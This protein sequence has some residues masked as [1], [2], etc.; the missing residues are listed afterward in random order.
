M[1][2]WH[3]F[4]GPNA[5]YVLELYDRYRESPEAVDPATRAIFDK[6]SPDGRGAPVAAEL[7]AAK[8]AG[9]INLAQAIRHYG[10]LAAALDP[11]RPNDRRDPLLELETHGLDED[12]LR[13]L[14]ASLVGGAAAATAA[15]A[16]EA[17]RALR[18]IYSSTMGYSYEH[19]HELRE[20]EWLRDAAE[21]RRFRPRAS[22]P[23]RIP[24]EYG[25]ETRP[26]PDSFDAVALLERLTR[27]EVLEHFLHRT[28]PGKTRFS[29]E[30]LDM[31]VPVLDALIWEAAG[32]GD[33]SRPRIRNVILGMAHRGRLNV[34]ANILNKPIRQILAEFQDPVRARDFTAREELGWTG[35]VKYHM[36]AQSWQRADSR[37]LEIAVLMPPNPSHLE[38]ID[39]VVEGMARAE[40]TDASAPGAPR[41]DPG[42]SLPVLVHGDASFPGQGIV[43]ETLN[44]SRL[45]GYRTGGTIHII[46]NNQLGYTTPHDEG[47]ST[48]YA[49]DL[50]K[51]F[52]IPIVHVN[53][54]DPEACIEAARLAAAYRAE[55]HKD[56][57]INLVGYRRYGHNEGD[58]PSFTQ[59]LMYAR[60][61]AHP[62]VRAQW[63]QTLVE[64]GLI[65]KELPERLVREYADELQRALEAVRPED[66]VDHAPPPPPQGAARRVKTAVPL[67]DLAALNDA[68]LTLPDGFALN[69]KLERAMARRRKALDDA[70]ARSIDW[71]TAEQLAFASILQAGTAIRFTGQDVERGTFSQR[72][73]V[74]HDVRTGATFTPLQS[75]PQA[76]AAF[77]IHNSPLSEEATIGFEY[78]YN[79]QK[80][81]RLVVWEAQ[82]GDF[83]NVA[84]SV[85]DEFLV[86]ARAKWGQTPSLVLLLPHAWE[87]QGPD[88][89]SGRLERFLALAA[90]TNLRIAFPTTAAQ[91]WH[92]L[93]RQALLLKTDPLPLIVMTPK[94]LLRDPRVAS[95][96]RELAEGQ[97]QPVL[98]DTEA[99]EHAEAIHRLLLCS[100]K[101]YFDLT[102]SEARKER[103]DTAIARVEQL[104]RFPTDDLRA[105]MNAYPNLREVVW[106]Q[107]EPENMGAWTFV[108]PRLLELLDGRIP[109]RHVA[110]SANS[111]PAEGSTARHAANQKHLIESAF[112]GME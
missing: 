31:L 45:E 55:F 62:S 72:H 87:G 105:V 112:K 51:G 54:D 74:F 92:L 46:A 29:I 22:S 8:I 21:S 102:A 86:S 42:V 60:I 95:S 75:L 48:L 5:G 56:L 93:R 24:S 110:R 58:E 82:Y 15:N 44:L 57:V 14:P 9:V 25:D 111:S 28:F 84:Q 71:A 100:G 94:S 40:G 52:E 65:D 73:A 85:I 16:W 1:D 39:P 18:A 81:D 78:G 26:T 106:V 61:A 67:R 33:E 68:L 2:L 36:G 41:F 63:A 103:S 101:V 27:V 69:P 53:A 13:R 96:P 43:A 6:W 64:R 19:I 107:E 88:H 38:A 79:V 98:D 66:L 70:D 35:D 59:P 12:D 23:S 99:R 77:E 3:E 20:R 80:P 4:P 109:L 17:I 83:I 76:R 89:S 7:P 37:A 34:L 49:S 32:R 11:L 97:W 91:Y 50:A 104:Y 47:R 90:E 10:H 108:Q 30:G